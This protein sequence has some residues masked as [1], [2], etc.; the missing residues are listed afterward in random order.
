MVVLLFVLAFVGV[1]SAVTPSGKYNTLIN[2]AFSLSCGISLAIAAIALL[3]TNKVA[4]SAYKVAVTILVIQSLYLLII[5]ENKFLVPNV[6]ATSVAL[7]MSYLIGR[8]IA[9]SVRPKDHD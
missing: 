5:M 2:R 6:L 4:Y 3:K 8:F 9:K 1:V 7:V